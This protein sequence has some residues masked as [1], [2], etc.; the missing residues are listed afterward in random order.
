ML[1]LSRKCGHWIV[2]CWDDA[3]VVVENVDR[4]MRQHG[5]APKQAAI[6]AMDEIT[7]AIIGITLVSHGSLYSCGLLGAFA[8]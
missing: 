4:N 5:L 8:A 7:G 3:I 1:T 6:R 2:A